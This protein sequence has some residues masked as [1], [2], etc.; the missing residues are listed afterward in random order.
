VNADTERRRFHRGLVIGAMLG[1]LLWGICALGV[2]A[3]LR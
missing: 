3:L 1:V 2:L